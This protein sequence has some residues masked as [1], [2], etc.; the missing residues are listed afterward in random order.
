MSSQYALE[1]VLWAGEILCF[2]SW[3][4][5]VDLWGLINDEKGREPH[6][7]GRR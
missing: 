1:M 2:V 3:A 6:R 5:R 7:T 4:L